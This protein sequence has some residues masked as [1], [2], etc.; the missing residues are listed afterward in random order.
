M[1]Y[2]IHVRNFKL[3]LSFESADSHRLNFNFVNSAYFLR[4][5]VHVEISK[6]AQF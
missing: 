4:L 6:I 5:Y 2:P 1:W 3:H